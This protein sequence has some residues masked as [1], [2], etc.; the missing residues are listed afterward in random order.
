[1]RQ[2]ASGQSDAAADTEFAAQQKANMDRLMAD[3]THTQ[4]QVKDL[5]QRQ[6]A[7]SNLRDYQKSQSLGDIQ[8]QT[9]EMNLDNSGDH[10]GAEQAHT[11]YE[12]DQMIQGAAGDPK[13]Q[14]ALRDQE[15]AA[16]RGEHGPH[17]EHQ[18]QHAQ[19]LSPM[20]E[21]LRM[22]PHSMG[23]PHA[24]TN[25][26]HAPA[27]QTEHHETFGQAVHQLAEG[28]KHLVT[29]AEKFAK[30]NKKELKAILMSIV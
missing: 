15:N 12:Y 24:P 2:R 7:E 20:Q 4:Q 26:P 23:E 22:Q 8:E 25:V 27:H 3:P 29:G 14:A 6:T 13:K 18:Q 30:N 1:M 21:W 28:A 10:L 11:R 17:D 9:K 5:Q 16:L 19:L